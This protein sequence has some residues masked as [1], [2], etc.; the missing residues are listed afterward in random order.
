[1]ED[2]NAKITTRTSL[3]YRN[4]WVLYKWMVEVPSRE[5]HKAM[6]FTELKSILN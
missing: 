6:L 1:M 2:V 5:G 4:Q 3:S